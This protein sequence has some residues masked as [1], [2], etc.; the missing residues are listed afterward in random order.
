MQVLVTGATGRIGSQVVRDLHSAGHA[1][2]AMAIPNDPGIARIAD[3]CTDVVEGKLED[4]AAVTEAVAGVDAVCHLG[5]ALTSRLASDEA[6]FEVNLRGT[7]NLLMAVRDRGAGLH[8]FIY[9]SSD[10]VYFVNRT[11]PPCFLPIDE[12]H[13]RIPGTIYGATKL[14]CEELCLTFRR[15]YGVPVTMI[16]FSISHAPAELI[17]PASVPGRSLF[18]S[19]AIR[20]L[21][22]LPEYHSLGRR[23]DGDAAL[24]TALRAV[25]DGTNRLFVHADEEGRATIM[26]TIDPRDA[27]AGALATLERPEAVGQAFNLG[28]AA[29]HSELDLCR[30]IGQRLGL[31]HAVV[32]TPY[33]RRDW[34]VS[35]AKARSLLGFEPRYSVFDMVDEAVAA[36][37]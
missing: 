18:V 32:R 3:L 34:Y 8:R 11:T 29:P 7:F 1:V 6:F 26:N 28:P 25:D 35:S 19:S 4:A 17:D 36:A 33:A 9:A 2:R 14:S 37:G 24:L 22:S 12:T 21:E 16:R 13:P 23:D 5:A 20:H 10:A 30:Y 31:E 27:S 15:A